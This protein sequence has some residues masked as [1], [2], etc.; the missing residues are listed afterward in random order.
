[1]AG[2]L[3]VAP[4]GSPFHREYVSGC[5]NTIE[6]PKFAPFIAGSEPLDTD[7]AMENPL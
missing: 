7:V 2:K 4:T 5:F 1:M 6:Y 3:Q